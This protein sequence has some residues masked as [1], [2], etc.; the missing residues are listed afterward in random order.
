VCLVAVGRTGGAVGVAGLRMEEPP[1]PAAARP[2]PAWFRKRVGLEPA[3]PDAAGPETEPVGSE[4]LGWDAA[5]P[6]GRTLGV[7][8]AIR[9]REAALVRRPAEWVGSGTREGSGTRQGW[10][11]VPAGAAGAPG[12]RPDTGVKA[13]A[14]P[15]RPGGVR[16][17]REGA[18]GS[19][20][21][22][23]STGVRARVV[24]AARRRDAGARTGMRAPRF[25]SCDAAKVS[26]G[27]TQR[28]VGFGFAM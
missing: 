10:G 19:A 18:V 23:P 12:D 4:P 27:G 8:A 5:G 13:G 6:A 25:L 14:G 21:G 17:G 11:D 24:R 9:R 22:A 15:G 2:G 3:E 7:R 1:Q 28:G 16:V 20:R 26:G